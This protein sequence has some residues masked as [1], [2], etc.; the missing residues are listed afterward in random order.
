MNENYIKSLLDNNLD[1]VKEQLAEDPYVFKKSAMGQEPKVLW[2]G[3]SDSRVPPNEI[4]GTKPGD[5]F[6]HRNIANL[7]SY[8]DFNFL[9]VLK[10]A[11]EYL[12]VEHVIVCGHYQC[13]GVKA[14]M[15]TA[16][17]GILDNWLLQI[18]DTMHF[19]EEELEKLADEHARFDRLVELSAI[20]QL[21]HL[22]NTNII[23]GAWEKGNKVQLHAWVY[24]IGSGFIKPI[25]GGIDS[26]ET[27]KRHC[28][29]EKAK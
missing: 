16:S 22:G 12:G 26:V 2:L 23:R 18:R 25:I 27:L 5:F 7:V 28:K 1:W 8:T 11:V 29:F 17:Y 21:S 13:G 24:N 19:Y 6:V 20:E 3:C 15:G 10:Y 9:S 14:A 4:T